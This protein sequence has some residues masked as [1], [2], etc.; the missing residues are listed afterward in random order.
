MKKGQ[1]K[2]QLV[3]YGKDAATSKG[4]FRYPTGKESTIKAMA[5]RLAKKIEGPVDIAYV[6]QEPWD[7]RYITTAAPSEHHSIGY[8]FERLS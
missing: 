5:G 7:E 2:F 6:G 8:R 4:T 1:L 3:H